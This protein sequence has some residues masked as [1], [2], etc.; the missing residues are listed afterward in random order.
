MQISE[1]GHFT[2]H[3]GPQQTSP[4]KVDEDF[5]SQRVEVR[6]QRLDSGLQIEDVWRT[7]ASGF[8]INLF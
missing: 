7:P 5:A 4:G 3:D 2:C 1:R 8:A 6:R